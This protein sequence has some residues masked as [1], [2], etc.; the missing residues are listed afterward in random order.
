MTAVAWL[1]LGS[2]IGLMAV[3]WLANLAWERDL[4]DL[5]SD[6]S[7]IAATLLSTGITMMAITPFVALVTGGG[8]Q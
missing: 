2:G 3:G 1:C 6:G 5:D 7:A 8:F 4:R